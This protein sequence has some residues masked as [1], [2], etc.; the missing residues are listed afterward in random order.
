MISNNIIS[1]CAVAQYHALE[2]LVK[3]VPEEENPCQPLSGWW[4]VKGSGQS[5]AC[6]E[7]TSIVVGVAVW[8]HT[9]HLGMKRGNPDLRKPSRACC[10]VV[11]ARHGHKARQCPP[12]EVMSIYEPGPLNI[13]TLAMSICNHMQWQHMRLGGQAA[14]W[15]HSYTYN[16]FQDLTRP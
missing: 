13:H 10:R 11:P 14:A 3:H 6:N 1:T 7:S 2:F 16:S 4:V 9:H 15:L 5:H 8:C 12:H